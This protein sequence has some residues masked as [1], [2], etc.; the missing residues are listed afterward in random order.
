MEEIEQYIVVLLFNCFLITC[1]LD[2]CK[3]FKNRKK[4]V[5]GKMSAFYVTAR[6]RQL[7][8]PQIPKPTDCYYEKM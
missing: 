7:K 4:T 2:F 8:S 3:G 1:E 5:L 6:F